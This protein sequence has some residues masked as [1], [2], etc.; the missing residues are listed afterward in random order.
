[1][2]WP[3]SSGDKERGNAEKRAPAQPAGPAQPPVGK[4]LSIAD[5]ARAR[6]TM[7]E[8]FLGRPGTPITPELRQRLH[9]DLV[10]AASTLPDAT[11]RLLPTVEKRCGLTDDTVQLIFRAWL[12]RPD[13]GAFAETWSIAAGLMKAVTGVSQPS[14]LC[15]WF[16]DAVRAEDPDVSPEFRAIATAHLTELV[17]AQF[18]KYAFSGGSSVEWQVMYAL[19]PGTR[20]EWYRRFGDRAAARGDKAGARRR[21]ALA[22]RFGG[23]SAAQPSRSPTRPGYTTGPS[24]RADH[25]PP[26]ATS[27]RLG[28]EMGSAPVTVSPPRK[29]PPTPARPPTPEP[30]ASSTPSRQTP[31]DVSRKLLLAASDVM[32]G[33]SGAPRLADSPPQSVEQPLRMAVLFVTALSRLRE[34]DQAAAEAE[35]REIIREPAELPA[36][37]DMHAN[38]HL[39]L[40]LL[41]QDSRLLAAGVRQLRDRHGDRWA[42]VSMV[43]QEAI[44]TM[45]ARAAAREAAA[46]DTPEASDLDPAQLRHAR[47]N[48]AE[49]TRSAL[50]SRAEEANASL[51]RVRRIIGVARGGQA[52]EL[53]RIADRIGD[54]AAGSDPSSPPPSA[55]LALTALRQD[56]VIRPWTQPAMRLWEKY[57]PGDLVSVHH[58][59]IA[60]HAKAYYLELEGDHTA[61]LHWDAALRHWATLYDSAEFWESMRGHLGEVMSDVT[62]PELERAIDRVRAD[63]PEQLLE[64]HATRIRTL[65]QK[66]PARARAHM[67]TIRTAPFPETVKSATRSRGGYEAEVAVRRLAKAGSEGQALDLVA[68]WLR[69]DPDSVQLA[70]AALDIGIDHMQARQNI[71]AQMYPARLLLDRITEM[72]APIN[73]TLGLTRSRTT[74]TTTQQWSAAV[75]AADRSAYAAKLARHEFWFGTCLMFIAFD[76]RHQMSALRLCG[77]AA[78]HF[79]WA[80]GLGLPDLP[81]YDSVRELLATASIGER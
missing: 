70:E 25:Q 67:R 78:G 12:R 39:V 43:D 75:S 57:D 21:Y 59:A 14:S 62:P 26:R 42:S 45:R 80:I 19:G 73:D 31:V 61:F 66:Q 20:A 49:A 24:R 63:L 56:G 71:S 74:A 69:V 79:R 44:S 8:T 40:G 17:D 77:E 15:V 64:P 7:I 36:D 5:Q 51:A 32:H 27:A 58:R 46:A 55:R 10:E 28:F 72:T 41:L 9:D 81:P 68:A 37:E 4:P 11:I 54:I 33:R 35:L 53:T 34:G 3:W 13:A 22:E 60:E 18:E 29:E 30:A 23:D 47:A 65:W 38:A 16:G 52:A 1:M 50:I 48:L 76:Q 6:L 2:K